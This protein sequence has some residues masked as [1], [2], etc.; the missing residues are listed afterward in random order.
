MSKACD[1]AGHVE[2]K[3]IELPIICVYMGIGQS[4]K[5]CTPSVHIKIAGKWM[6]IPLKCYPS[7]LYIYN[8]GVSWEYDIRD[9]IW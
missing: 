9:T 5:P 6:F 8:E 2:L 4:S 1:A 7:I 3:G